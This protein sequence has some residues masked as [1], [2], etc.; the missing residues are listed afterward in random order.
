MSINNDIATIRKYGV[1]M[2]LVTEQD[3]QFIVDLRL[4]KRNKYIS[5]TDPDVPKQIEW[6]KK[7]KIREENQL[8]Y[9]FIVK[10]ID[11]TSWG[12]TRIYNFQ[13][14]E[15]EVGSWVFLEN[16]PGGIAIKADI[17]AREMAF[18]VLNFEICKFEVRKDNKKVLRYHYGYQ[19]TVVAEDDLNF[20]FKLDKASFYRQRDKLLKLL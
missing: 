9:Y 20:Y 10:D 6:I 2:Q 11:G 14:N 1:V 3:A 15:F 13:N 5:K 8:E 4:N 19:P 7:Y 12:T 16:A 18:E 17:I